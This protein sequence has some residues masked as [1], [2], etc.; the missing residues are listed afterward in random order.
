MKKRY[1][2]LVLD[3]QWRQVLSVT[4]SLGKRGIRVIVGDT[5]RIAIGKFSRYCHE[6]LTYPDPVADPDAFVAFLLKF[7]RQRRIDLIIPAS[8]PTVELLARHKSVLENYTRIPLPD[9]EIVKKALDKALTFKAAIRAGVPCPK[10]WFIENEAEAVSLADDLE[11]PVII[12]PR[13]ATGALGYQEVFSKDAFVRTYEAVHRTFPL[14]LV[15]EFIPDGGGKYSCGPIFNAQGGLKATFVHNYLR[16]LPCN[17]GVGTLAC[18]IRN[19][20]VLESALRLLRALNWYGVA[21]VEFKTDPRDGLPKLLEINPRFWGM[22]QVAVCAGMDLPYH[23]FA[24]TVLNDQTPCSVYREGQYLRWM[25]PGDI[26][27]FITN[28]DRKKI[29]RDF[30]RFFDKNTSYY[31]ISKD[32]PLPVLG[33]FI[34]SFIGVFVNEEIKM[35]MKKLFGQFFQGIRSGRRAA[36]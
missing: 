11:Y 7:V 13:R 25:I 6:T 10:T 17:A 27:H 16:Q 9:Y 12:K 21:E 20:A 8:E 14:P 1:Y 2:V 22:S 18:S 32:D 34:V 33:V 19:D 31:I 35:A 30:F 36:G 24:M 28:P 23:L 4:R 15:Q 26:L 5:S 3:G 29:A